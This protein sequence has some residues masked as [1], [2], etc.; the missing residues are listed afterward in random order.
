MAG[1]AGSHASSL[2]PIVPGV[3]EAEAGMKHLAE[4][5]PIPMQV[6]MSSQGA[7]AAGVP[8]Q[9]SMPPPEAAKP[10]LDDLM[11]QAQQTV[12]A[13]KPSLDDLMKD[14]K[15]TAPK[16][17]Y[18]ISLKD[19]GNAVVDE[20]PSIGMVAGGV[21]GAALAS[22]SIVTGPE[23]PAAA[24]IGGAGV[25]KML[26]KSA[27]D[28]IYSATGDPRA[29]KTREGMAMGW[30]D[31][32]SSGMTDQAIGEVGGAALKAVPKLLTSAAS[33]TTG[34]SKWGIETYAKA[35]DKI[36]GVLEK[37]GK[38]LAGASDDIKA[39]FQGAIDSAKSS[40]NDQI[41]NTLKAAK[42]FDLKTSVEPVLKSLDE[43]VGTASNAM[44]KMK[45]EEIAELKTLRDKILSVAD[46]SGHAPVQEIHELKG[47]LQEEAANAYNA[48]A[49]GVATPGK[50]SFYE[51]GAR[52]AAAA[53]R[54]VVDEVAPE[55]TQ[56]N[57][58][59]QKFYE[60]QDKFSSSLLNAKTGDAAIVSAGRGANPKTAGD[61]IE[62]GNLTGKN[63]LAEAQ[64]YA[65]AKDLG[66]VKSGWTAAAVR[67]AIKAGQLPA[68]LIKKLGG[69]KAVDALINTTYG[70][71]FLG[72]AI[73]KAQQGVGADRIFKQ[74]QKP[75]PVDSEA[76]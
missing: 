31:A 76:K 72:Q 7:P 10:S 71:A 67:T 48:G 30:V 37:Y 60:L 34:V 25:G 27:Q 5:Q 49:N 26:G 22:P 58:E 55:V 29:P 3:A 12:P 2:A 4:L 33:K 50:G 14:A 11:M 39:G 70:K 69:D 65:A 57:T 74:F 56:A 9:P 6:P 62:L 18:D 28:A 64:T 40:L 23:I 43:M 75:I 16:H 59:L 20:L 66:G 35:A 17:W 32:L 63:H 46:E 8:T 51:Q 47:L 54:G 13:E 21:G 41:T 53:A 44:K 52:K 45:P 19:V 15:A 73:D 24:A 42:K 1:I 38:E 36:D 68:P 61:L